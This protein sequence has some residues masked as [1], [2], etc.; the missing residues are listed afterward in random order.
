[1]ADEKGMFVF[2]CPL[3]VDPHAIKELESRFNVAHHIYN[4]FLGECQR[5]RKKH[6]NSFF[7][8]QAIPFFILLKKKQQELIKLEEQYK[9]SKDVNVKS[10]IDALKVEI[11]TIKGRC[12][13][14]FDQAK[15][16]SGYY[17]RN[18]EKYG[19]TNGLET[20]ASAT[21][22]GKW[23][24]QHIDSHCRN[25]LMERAFKAPVREFTR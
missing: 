12:D 7:Y 11:T 3:Y 17:L 16:E 20:F 9:L 19:K 14:H 24:G 6:N 8:K 13:Y 1:M 2:T 22:Q 18:S 5:R 4:C 25:K 21:I 15:I 23:L 10:N